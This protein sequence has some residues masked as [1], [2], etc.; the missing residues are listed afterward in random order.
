MNLNVSLTRLFEKVKSSGSI[1][2]ITKLD[3]KEKGASK[4]SYHFGYL[5]G[6]PKNAPFAEECLICTRVMECMVPPDE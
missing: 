1:R 4:C 2:V 6:Q 3:K 5:F